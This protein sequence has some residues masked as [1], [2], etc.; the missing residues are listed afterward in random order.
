VRPDQLRASAS[1][2]RPDRNQI[3]A[4]LERAMEHPRG[5]RLEFSGG[6]VVDVARRDWEPLRDERQWMIEFPSD[7]LRVL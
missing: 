4:Q 6:V 3:P 5:M 7:S 1:H 2:G